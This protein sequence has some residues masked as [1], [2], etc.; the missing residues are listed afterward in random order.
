MDWQALQ[1]S[2]PR[3]KDLPARA[4]RLTALTA[5]LD[6]TLY[7]HVPY[8]FSEEMSPAGEYIPLGS[9][10]PSV[11]SG[12]PRT[13]TEDSVALLF[14]EGHF[15]QVHADDRTTVEVLGDW[16]KERRLNEVFDDAATRGSV[17]SVALLFKVLRSKPFVSVMPTA[18]LTPTWDPEDPDAL[19]KVTE[20]YKLKALQLRAAG[21]AVP[22]TAN[23][24]E[25]FWFQRSWDATEETW[26][27]P[28]SVADAKQ[29][30]QPVRDAERSIVHG[31]GFMPVIWVRNLRGGDDID[32]APTFGPSAI[33]T[34]IEVDY[35]LSQAGRGL[36]YASDPRLVVRDPSG[37]DKPLTGGAANAIVL[38][39]PESDA[40][41]LEING[42]AAAA[43]IEYVRYLRSVALESMHGNRA[44][45]DKLAA[46][47]SGRAMEL[48]CMALVSLADRLRT[49]YGEGALLALMRMVCLA[50]TKVAGGLL[51]GGK[52]VSNLQPDGLSLVWP[53]WFA[54]TPG[55]KQATAGMLSTLV[56]RGIVSEQTATRLMSGDLDIEDVP[57]ERALIAAEKVAADTRLAQQAGVQTKASE[58]I[59]S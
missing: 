23:D 6:G 34:M 11:L 1:A 28:L 39:S 10:R 41:F 3:D 19:L 31:L 16:I 53:A 33:S 7:D 24:N 30:Q 59:T 54:P 49:S 58:T 43:V 55:D 50:S 22:I 56:S 46:A 12:I 47:Q 20:R 44:D 17:G 18:Y 21:Y 4:F 40:K 26:F 35:Q 9:R 13:V 25:W 8:A 32:G 42:T 29:G 57:A 38:G 15:P 14:S 52:K 36:K 37:A 2:M 45:A 5:V 51:I 48:M 27:L